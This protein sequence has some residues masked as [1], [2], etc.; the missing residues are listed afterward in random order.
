PIP[1][2]AARST[3]R[4]IYVPDIVYESAHRDR[5]LLLPEGRT[6]GALVHAIPL[7]QVLL[8]HVVIFRFVLIPSAIFATSARSLEIRRTSDP[9]SREKS[10]YL[11][12]LPVFSNI[13]TV[14]PNFD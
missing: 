11:H 12:W 3:T 8:V 4:C 14:C 5:H 13:K 2:E 1:P 6:R 7:C 9:G 10:N